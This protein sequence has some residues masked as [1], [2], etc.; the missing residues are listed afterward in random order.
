MVKGC[1]LIEAQGKDFIEEEW[2][3]NKEIIDWL[4]LKTLV[5]V[6]DWLSLGFDFLTLR[7]LQA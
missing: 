1:P 6:C 4:S 5:A 2:K 3:L 7:H